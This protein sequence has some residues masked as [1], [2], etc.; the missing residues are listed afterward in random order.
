[1]GLAVVIVAQRPRVPLKVV[2]DWRLPSL[3]R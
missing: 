2:R 1:M 3:L